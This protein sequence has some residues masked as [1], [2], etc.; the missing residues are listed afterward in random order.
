M[1]LIILY[2]DGAE[3]I[4]YD[5][6]FPLSNIIINSKLDLGKRARSNLLNFRHHEI[7]TNARDSHRMLLVGR[8]PPRLGY[9]PLQTTCNELPCHDNSK[10][11]HDTDCRANYSK[12]E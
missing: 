10:K 3:R 6:H 9:R 4:L 8:L 11:T 7:A 5:L 12:G 2:H 1:A